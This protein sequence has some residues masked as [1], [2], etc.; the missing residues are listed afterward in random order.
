MTRAD[1]VRSNHAA[2]S[3]QSNV[4]VVFLPI[5]SLRLH[6]KGLRQYFEAMRREILADGCLKYPVIADRD[7]RVILDGAHRWLALK[8]LGCQ[9]IPT[10]LVDVNQKPGV[11]VGTRRIHRYNGNSKVPIQEVIS[12]GLKGQLMGPRSTR[13]FFPFSKFQLINRSLSELG[14]GSPKDVSQFLENTP[15]EKGEA[16]M[17]DWLN[18]ISEEIVFLA[19]RK[20]EVEKEHAELKQRVE[21]MKNERCGRRDLDPGQRLGRPTS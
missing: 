8:S 19:Q 16:I 12:A 11:R 15:K 4:E 20:E 7:S 21:S 1:A 5:D 2:S 10:L 9:K 14:Q 6:E 3:R 17:Q 13:H 18:E